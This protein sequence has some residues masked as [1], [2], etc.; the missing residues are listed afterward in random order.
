M[1]S[2]FREMSYCYTVMRRSFECDPA[3]ETVTPVVRTEFSSSTVTLGVS[4]VT[5]VLR[6]VQDER[7]AYRPQ[8]HQAVCVACGMARVETRRPPA[9]QTPPP[10]GSRR[11]GRIGNMQFFNF[12]LLHLTYLKLLI[13]AEIAPLVAR[14]MFYASLH[15]SGAPWPALDE[16]DHRDRGRRY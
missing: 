6:E 9:V 11:L 4:C 7:L 15:F 16:K 2:T 13:R 10:R 5:Y 12:Y 3:N 14:N 1:H 8:F